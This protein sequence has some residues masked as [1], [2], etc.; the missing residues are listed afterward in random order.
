MLFLPVGL[1][2]A[3]GGTALS[4][5]GW[6][7]SVLGVNALLVA[8]VFVP[9]GFINNGAMLSSVPPPSTPCAAVL[10]GSTVL[11]LPVVVLV[12]T[13]PL[14]VPALCFHSNAPGDS[15]FTSGVRYV[16]SSISFSSTSRRSGE[17]T[18]SLSSVSA[19][20]SRR[21][22]TAAA[23]RGGVGDDAMQWFMRQQ[24]SKVRT[25]VC[26]GNAKRLSEPIFEQD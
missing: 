5:A 17:S 18:G 13:A 3:T 15:P 23:A 10:T 14:P 9:L 24:S 4:A 20:R 21:S 8:V 12:P 16:S 6:F 11:V 22:T 26:D 25:L 7:V 2:V 1:L 19:I